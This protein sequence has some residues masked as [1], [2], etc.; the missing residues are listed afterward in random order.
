VGEGDGVTR[1]RLPILVVGVVLVVL[2][3]GAAWLGRGFLVLDA[4]AARQDVALQG[5]VRVEQRGDAANVRLAATLDQRH[6]SRVLA[7]ILRTFQAAIVPRGRNRAPETQPVDAEALVAK[8]VPRLHDRGERAQAEV[9]L[10][11][12][13][14]AAA[15][16]G[17][18]TLESGQ[19]TGGNL[20]LAQA[21]HHFQEA[22]RFDSTNEDAKYDLELL[23]QEAARTPSTKPGRHG[24]KQGKKTIQPPI[25]AQKRPDTPQ[26]SFA[27]PGT[28]Y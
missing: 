5:A 3:L 19:G 1:R 4:A 28:G 21:L 25:R 17:N 26:A 15:G 14:A 27:N 20:L 13:L 24:H 9:V 11:I 10:G 16:N 8:L 7:Q 2:A 12:L 18:G 6:R 22:V 23:L